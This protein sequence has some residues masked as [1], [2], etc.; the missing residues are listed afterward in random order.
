[1]PTRAAAPP[2]HG[3][4]PATSARR[5]PRGFSL[6]ELLV[7]LALLSLVL[8]MIYGSFFQISI[9]TK[10]INA[11]L[12][13]R[14]ELRLLLKIISDDFQA[15]RHFQWFAAGEGRASGIVAEREFVN[16]EVF[17]EVAFHA[18]LPTRFHRKVAAAADPEMHEVAYLV[19]ASRNDRENLV[20]VRR[21]DF[22]LD[23]DMEDGGISVVLADRIATFTVSFLARAGQGDA[24]TETWDENWDSSTRTA[25]T[26]MPIAVR[27][28]LARLGQNGKIREETMEVNLPGSMNVGL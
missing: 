21:E 13:D 14:Q 11:Q 1:M 8:V 10:N 15:A 4:P 19:R 7:A 25:K 6:I 2:R 5:Q 26:R 18:A 22:F 9:G 24:D 27:I 3:S 16:S 17:S 28:T 20:L 12:S 23:D